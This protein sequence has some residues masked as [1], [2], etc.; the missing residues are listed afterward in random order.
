MRAVGRIDELDGN[1]HPVAH[2]SHVSTD[3]VGGPERAAD[4]A[5]V[6]ALAAERK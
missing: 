2:A 1:A 5:H 6:H 3:H 4:L